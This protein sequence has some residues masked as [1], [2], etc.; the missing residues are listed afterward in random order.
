M[1]NQFKRGINKLVKCGACGK[2]THSDV[3]GM[4]LSLCPKCLDAA[5]LTN[6]HSDGYHDDVA[7]PHCPECKSPPPAT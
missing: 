3:A 1:T 4:G 5:E 7:D 6:A 2:L